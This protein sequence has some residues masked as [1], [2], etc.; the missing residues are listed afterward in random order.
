M[1]APGLVLVLD[2]PARVGK[3]ATI[4]VLQRRWPDV[5]PG[6]LLEA[7]LDRSLSGLG[8]SLARWWPLIQGSAAG[9]PAEPD[10][11]TWGP[12]GRELIAAM[13][14]AAAAWSL[15]GFDVAI[16]HILLD[17]ATATDLAEALE[18][19]PVLHV[20]L[21]C[22]PD[23]LARREADG[24]DAS[25]DRAAAQLVATRD[26]AVRDVLVDTTDRSVEDVAE[27]VLRHVGKHLRDG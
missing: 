24:S 19:L 26:V 18:S 27:V 1:T 8:S 17:Q 9:Q 6:P 21:T 23:E 10:Q 2:G 14:R 22:D 7:G 11:T 4:E 25:L 5:Q 13:H 3:S 20:G 15:A 16:D 12:L